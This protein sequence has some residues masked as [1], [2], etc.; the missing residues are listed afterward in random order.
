MVPAKVTTTGIR[1][2][3]RMLKTLLPDM[4]EM[5]SAVLDNLGR[6]EVET[7]Q[8]KETLER[9]EVRVYQPQSNQT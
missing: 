1:L 4:V 8:K 9:R 3:L 2:D 7:L 5:L 6:Q